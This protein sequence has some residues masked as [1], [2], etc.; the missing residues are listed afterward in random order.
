[1][2]S[3]Y[4]RLR[5]TLSTLV[6]CA[7]AGSAEDEAR[8]AFEDGTRDRGTAAD[9]QSERRGRL[10]PRPGGPE[11]AQSHAG[12]VLPVQH[13][14]S[15]VS[16]EGTQQAVLSSAHWKPDYAASLFLPRW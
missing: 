7:W 10:H 1:M 11:A 14:L 5:I 2:S 12:G 3:I 6:T 4:R 15:A 9:H 8:T 13:Q 16:R